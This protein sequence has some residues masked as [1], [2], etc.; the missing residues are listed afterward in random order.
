M[1]PAHGNGTSCD[2]ASCEARVVSLRML[3]PDGPGLSGRQHGVVI[4]TDEEDATR[5]FVAVDDHSFSADEVREIACVLHHWL[6][7]RELPR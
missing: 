5:L 6:A 7:T 1:S 2:G 4:E 3:R